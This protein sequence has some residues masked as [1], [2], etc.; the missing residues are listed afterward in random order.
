MKQRLGTLFGVDPAA[1]GHNTI[2]KTFV[3]R[4][5]PVVTFSYAGT[6]Y[7]RF[8]VFGGTGANWPQSRRETLGYLLQNLGEW[9]PPEEPVTLAERVGSAW[10]ATRRAVGGT[11]ERLGTW[12]NG[13]GRRIV[14]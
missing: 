6:D 7:L 11:V 8:A 9:E 3:A 4:S 2:N 13:V 14:G 1:I 5:T 12:V 10:S